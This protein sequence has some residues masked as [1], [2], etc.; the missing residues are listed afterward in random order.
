MLTF[1]TNESLINIRLEDLNP[2]IEVAKNKDEAQ[3]TQALIEATKDKFLKN[4]VNIF[5]VTIE[6]GICECSIW[7]ELKHDY[8]LELA[9]DL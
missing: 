6:D 7:D 8:I 1:K 5:D 4:H 9:F 2:V 3:T